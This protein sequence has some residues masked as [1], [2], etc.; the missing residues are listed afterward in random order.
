[1]PKTL[2]D[3]DADLLAQATQILGT[4]TKKDAV[5][6]ALREVVRRAAA[7]AFLTR[8]RSGVFGIPAGPDPRNPA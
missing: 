7:V 4:R 1:M 5:N 2:I 6:G 3:I 8:A